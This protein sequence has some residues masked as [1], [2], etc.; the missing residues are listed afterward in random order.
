MGAITDISIYD[1]ID[2]QKLC[3]RTLFVPFASFAEAMSMGPSMIN[4]N[5][6]APG[7]VRTKLIC[8]IS[9]L[10]LVNVNQISRNVIIEL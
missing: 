10:I 1:L 4:E 5:N 9:S 3:S 8:S 6:F 2:R 7:L